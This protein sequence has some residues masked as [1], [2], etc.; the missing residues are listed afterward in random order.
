MKFKGIATIS[1]LLIILTIGI[2]SASDNITLE[3]LSAD[4]SQDI[5]QEVSGDSLQVSSLNG[6]SFNDIQ[7]AVDKSKKDD[8]IELEGYFT[9][10]RKEIVV[11][12]DLTIQG[13]SKGATLDAKKL[14]AVFQ[15]KSN[16]ILKNLVIKNS[17]ETAIDFTPDG[18]KKLTIINCTFYNNDGGQYGNGGIIFCNSGSFTMINSTIRDNTAIY[19]GA[20]YSYSLTDDVFEII[21]CTF[22]NNDIGAI[23]AG[24]KFNI[25][26]STF[27][28]NGGADGNGGAIVISDSLNVTN[29][30]FI[31]NNA[32][33]GGAIYVDRGNLTVDNCI[34]ENNVATDD[35]GSIYLC[36]EL[37]SDD[38]IYCNVWVKNSNFTNSK[39]GR[40]GAAIYTIF[41]NL[42]T[43]NTSI[44]AP[45]GNNWIYVKIGDLNITGGDGW[46]IEKIDKI[47]A[48]LNAKKFT[49]TYD[50]QNW[51]RV[52]LVDSETGFSMEERSI[53][54]KVFTGKSSKEYVKISYDD[55]EDGA[56]ASL[57]IDKDYSIGKH[58]VEIVSLSKYYDVE[59]L[60]T[61]IT[62]NKAKTV[63]KA[64]TVKAKYKKSKKFTV[65]VKNK[66]SYLNVKGI[67]VKIKVYTGKKSTT[68]KVKTDKK[69]VAQIN[70]K[71][72]KRGTH[73]VKITSGDKRYVISKKSK[74]IIK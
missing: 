32:I 13:S 25:V 29:S 37:Y 1:I 9:S 71:K 5:L 70:T 51:F 28:N 43:D 72:L 38:V 50:S 57:Y 27:E 52:A 26:N 23:Y 54:F 30:R 64:P 58:K 36:G 61:Y 62:V 53:R 19:G 16:L 60:T 39:A 18:Y 46:D 8:V 31:N 56:Y 42:K 41:A 40:D 49:T 47:K 65:K 69:G 20:I 44:I 10:S 6:S 3:D 73:K 7:A 68:F 14:S 12:K 67:V 74:I 2:V 24:S 55:E 35:G 21:N 17:G 48:T 59:N 45:T 15:V 33:K 34:F 63:V 22:K 4:N 11:K 66:A